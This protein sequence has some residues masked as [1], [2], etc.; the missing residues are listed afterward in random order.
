[1]ERLDVTAYLARLGLPAEPPSAGALAR[2]HTAHLERVPYENLDIQ[3]GRVTSLD[4]VVSARRIQRGRGGYCYHLNGAFSAL[5]AA[6]G[7]HVTRHPAGVQVTADA[8]AVIDHNHLA[9]TVT[10]LPDDPETTWLADVGLGDALYEPIPLREGEYTQGPHT[11][12]LRPSRVVTGGWRLDHD[13]SGVVAGM[14]F[15]PGAAVMADFAARHEWLSTAPESGYVRL[16]LL[17][18]RDA[19]GVDAIQAL[20]LTRHGDV[21][22]TE[23][24]ESP[25]QWWTAAADVFGIPADAFTPDERDE[26]WRAARSQHEFHLRVRAAAGS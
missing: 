7:Y 12:R 19:T 18:R 11:Y 26:L 16:L 20:T 9:V 4:P 24:L 22:R 14:D 2:L 13:P 21:E 25:E 17:M 6:L 8:G 23:L 15:A 3:L 10:G 5:L 1:M